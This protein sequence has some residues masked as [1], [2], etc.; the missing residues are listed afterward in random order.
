MLHKPSDKLFGF[1]CNSFFYSTCP[2]IFVAERNCIVFKSFNSVV[3][4]CY[5]VRIVTQVLDNALR[6]GK[7][8]LTIY[9]P[10]FSITKGFYGFKIRCIVGQFHFAISNSLA[11]E[12][13]KYPAEHIAEKFYWKEE[14]F[15]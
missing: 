11:D 13:A 5:T 6:P 14:F 1:Q 7:W 4:D 10:V 3:R 12:P 8:F 15:R 9:H 2:V